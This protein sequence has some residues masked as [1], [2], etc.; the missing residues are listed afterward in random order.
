MRSPIHS[1]Q[2][3]STGCPIESEKK[4]VQEVSYQLAFEC[5]DR[6]VA[7][8][9]WRDGVD[10]VQEEKKGKD[11]RHRYDGERVITLSGFQ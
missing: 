2:T 8:K 6:P 5:L 7:A 3:Q 9:R 10:H 1:L 4:L 11:E